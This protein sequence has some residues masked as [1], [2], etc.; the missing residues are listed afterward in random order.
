MDLG[1]TC[2]SISWA[3][4]LKSEEGTWGR[5]YDRMRGEESS[6]GSFCLLLFRKTCFDV[7][8]TMRNLQSLFAKGIECF[9]WFGVHYCPLK[10]FFFFQRLQII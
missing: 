5:F 9:D 3:A 1:Q 8:E 6:S 2:A 4:E 10:K 7:I